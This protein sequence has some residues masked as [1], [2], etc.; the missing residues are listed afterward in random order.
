MA[1]RA[2]HDELMDTARPVEAQAPDQFVTFTCSDRAFGIDIMSVREIRSWSPTTELP[3]QPHGARGVLD[4]RGSVV[5]VYDLAVMLGG[6]GG[7][8]NTGQV[9]L[10]V[11]LDRQDVGLLVDSVSDIIFAQPEDLRS[12]PLSTSGRGNSMVKG[13]FKNEDRL[14]AILNL[15]AMFP[16]EADED[17]GP[18]S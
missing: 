15:D 11:S 5:Q 8:A 14:I 13:M 16:A 4:I 9:V 17:I 18:H 2:L 3:G 6:Q 7:Q 10:V 1:A 12:V